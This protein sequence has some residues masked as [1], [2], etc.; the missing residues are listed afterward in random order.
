[1][2]VSEC[3]GSWTRGAHW[4]DEIISFL[5][6]R[7]ITLVTNLP[8]SRNVLPSMPKL[9][10]ELID[11]SILFS[12]LLSSS[13]SS[14]SS[15]SS[16]IILLLPLLPLFFFHFLF[17]LPTAAACSDRSC[18]SPP[19]TATPATPATPALPLSI[20]PTL[21]LV[22]VNLCFQ[23]LGVWFGMDPA[24]GLLSCVWA[25]CPMQLL[26]S[27]EIFTLIQSSRLHFT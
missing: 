2:K 17:S 13:F 16:S 7:S 1:M 3:F 27:F 5:A 18:W 8:V 6:G 19:S 25:D 9:G 24:G 20:T 10:E 12:F 26:F 14:S 21:L 11:F 22:L 4:M 15:S 23:K